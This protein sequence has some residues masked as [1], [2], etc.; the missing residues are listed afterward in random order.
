[1]N[2]PLQHSEQ[3]PVMLIHIEEQGIG[4]HNDFMSHLVLSSTSLLP[5]NCL[6]I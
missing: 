5:Q 4:H 6:D 1:M 2:V 3:L